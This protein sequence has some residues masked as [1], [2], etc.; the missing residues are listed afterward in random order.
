MNLSIYLFICLSIDE[1][2]P[3]WGSVS[4]KCGNGT[5]DL[6]WLWTISGIALRQAR[7]DP[8]TILRRRERP[9]VCPGPRIHI[10]NKNKTYIG[11]L[12]A[13]WRLNMRYLAAC[14]IKLPGQKCIPVAKTVD[15]WCLL[16]KY[17]DIRAIWDRISLLTWLFILYLLHLLLYLII[18][19]L[20]PN[21][22]IYWQ[23]R[24]SPFV[25]TSTFLSCWANA[26][27]LLYVWTHVH[28]I[29]RRINSHQFPLQYSKP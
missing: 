25:G 24:S 12:L 1:R 15:F 22:H 26:V 16:V 29:F 19:L 8:M 6:C 14:C 20:Q 11:S 18:H 2:K 9:S 5:D 21:H 7:L 28:T 10:H 17:S 13:R 27:H 23:H 3:W 4:T